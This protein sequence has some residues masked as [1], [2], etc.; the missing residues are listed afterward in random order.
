MGNSLEPSADRADFLDLASAAV[1]RQPVS[2]VP[3]NTKPVSIARGTLDYGARYKAKEPEQP[4]HR[5]ERSVEPHNL[6]I[7]VAPSEARSSFRSS[8]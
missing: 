1:T 2:R 5:P 4:A 7:H 8:P 6:R 3:L